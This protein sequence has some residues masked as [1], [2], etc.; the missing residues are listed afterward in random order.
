MTLAEHLRT[1]ALEPFAWGVADCCLFP[2]DWILAQTGIDAAAPLRGRYRTPLGAARHIKR[3]GG[4]VRMVSDLM[5]AAGFL[6]TDNP[7]PGDVGVIHLGDG[8]AFAIR[9]RV[10]WASKSL[11]GL[12]CGPFRHVVA[13]T[14][15]SRER[16]Q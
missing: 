13:W 3:R 14:I 4:F 8:L 12:G 7:Q 2:S 15:P 6:E 1:G 10:G 11:S 5:A 16:P 9:T